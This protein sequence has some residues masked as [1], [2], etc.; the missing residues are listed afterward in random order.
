MPLAAKVIEDYNILQWRSRYVH[1]PT[2]HIAKDSQR[3]DLVR[4]N[5][6]IVHSRCHGLIIVTGVTGSIGRLLGREL[7]V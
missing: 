1:I 4:P 7:T 6:N 5:L 3:R 2:N